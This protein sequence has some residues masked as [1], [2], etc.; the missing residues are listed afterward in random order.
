M[1]LE[2][3]G[4]ASPAAQAA[5][6]G[7]P[8][9][10]VILPLYNEGANLRAFL[11]DVKAALDRTGYPFE[12]IL[13]DDGSPDDTWKVISDEARTLPVIRAVRLSRNFG[14]ELAL[15]AG[16]ERARGDAI[17]LMDGDGQHPPA[18]L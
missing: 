13:I 4:L 17:V 18:L 9:I 2:K 7:S 1:K 6:H 10:S 8:L 16:L 15:C 12:L 3:V 5:E 11:S 14:K